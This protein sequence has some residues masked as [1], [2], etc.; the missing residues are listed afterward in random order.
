MKKKERQKDGVTLEDIEG[1]YLVS[2]GIKSGQYASSIA[3]SKITRMT[4][5]T[6]ATNSNPY[7]SIDVTLK[8]AKEKLALLKAKSIQ[9]DDIDEPDRK[10]KF[11][12]NENK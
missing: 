4:G 3:G 12:K 7:N 11:L 5:K 8:I 10:K 2:P 9:I 6:N 1:D